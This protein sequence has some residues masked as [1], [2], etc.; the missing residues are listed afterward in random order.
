MSYFRVHIAIKHQTILDN[1]A[2]IADL[3]LV[4]LPGQLDEPIVVLLVLPGVPQQLG[5]TRHHRGDCALGE[6]LS[7]RPEERID[8]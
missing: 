7:A 8:V 2:K 4:E 5:Q 1:K 3:N 6:A